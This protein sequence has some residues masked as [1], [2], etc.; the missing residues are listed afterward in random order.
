M[1]FSAVAFQLQLTPFVDAQLPLPLQPLQRFD[2][3]HLQVGLVTTNHQCCGD[4][5]L[6]EGSLNLQFLLQLKAHIIKYA[7]IK[8]N[9]AK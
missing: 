6:E 4:Y 1:L 3:C 8:R 5:I 9:L 2:E 7:Q